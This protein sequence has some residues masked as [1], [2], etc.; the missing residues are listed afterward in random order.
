MVQISG[1]GFRFNILVQVLRLDFGCM[2]PVQVLGL[3]F[4]FK[5]WFQIQGFTSC[6]KDLTLIPSVSSLSQDQSKQSN[7][8]DGK[9][10]PAVLFPLMPNRHFLAKFWNAN[11]LRLFCLMRQKH[12]WKYFA[13][14]QL[15]LAE[16]KITSVVLLPPEAN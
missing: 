11:K 15:H 7:S 16:G 2:F 3:G 9:I 1:L 12:C 5:F 10:T 14:N 8:P 6:N 4:G 13:F